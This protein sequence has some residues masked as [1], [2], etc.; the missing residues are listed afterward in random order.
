MSADGGELDLLQTR[1]VLVAPNSPDYP[2]ATSQLAAEVEVCPIELHMCSAALRTLG[3]AALHVY[4]QLVQNRATKPAARGELPAIADDAI[5]AAEVAAGVAA[6]MP[7]ALPS[8]PCQR[9]PSQSHP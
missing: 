3:G 8:L 7:P 2:S 9:T 4:E 5:V 1:L 6:A